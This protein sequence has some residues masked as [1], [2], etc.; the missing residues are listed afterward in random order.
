MHVYP[1]ASVADAPALSA[2]PSPC[3]HAAPAPH[4]T[5]APAPRVTSAP[6]LCSYLHL[7]CCGGL[8]DGR[9]VVQQ[10]PSCSFAI[11]RVPNF[12]SAFSAFK[13]TLMC[14]RSLKNSCRRAP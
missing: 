8:R 6:R 12:S 14:D 13:L 11:L 5:A 1:V 7:C 10:W 9:V 4:V 3:L 2:R